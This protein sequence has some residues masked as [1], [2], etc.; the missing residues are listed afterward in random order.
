MNTID[1]CS[2][3]TKRNNDLRTGIENGFCNIVNGEK[4]FIS[5]ALPEISP[6]ATNKQLDTVSDVERALLAIA[7]SAAR[8]AFPGW[9]AV[10]FEHR[11]TMLTDVLNKIDKNANDLSGRLAA[12]QGGTLAEAKWEIDLLTKSF[13]AVL[14]S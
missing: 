13:G 6:V 4:I 2:A 9:D 10:P 3:A 12:E 8:N 11:K 7:I 5:K 1:E 14:V